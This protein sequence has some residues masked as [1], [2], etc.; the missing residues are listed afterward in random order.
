MRHFVLSFLLVTICLPAFAQ[1]AD[2]KPVVISKDPAS[3]VV[4]VVD[5]ETNSHTKQSPQVEDKA[6]AISLQ[7][8]YTADIWSNAKGGIKTGTRYLD[9][10]DVMLNVDLEA[11]VGIPNTTV[12]VYGLYNNGKS[13]TGDLTGDAQGISNIETGTRAAK[14]YEA[15]IQH[16][17]GGAR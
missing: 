17:F 8:V 3:I 12:F 13:F 15:W 7:V 4:P 10:L 11:A 9:N 5:I 16:D 2:S 1:S 6:D 14:L